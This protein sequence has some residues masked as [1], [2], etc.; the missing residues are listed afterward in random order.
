MWRPLALLAGMTG[1]SRSPFSIWN[2]RFLIKDKKLKVSEDINH[3]ATNTTLTCGPA[4]SKHVEEKTHE[5]V[6]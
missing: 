2:K 1:C 5:R 4:R 3:G 6:T